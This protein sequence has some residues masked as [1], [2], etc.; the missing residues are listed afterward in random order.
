[1]KIMPTEL[2]AI[3]CLPLTR[4]GIY[5]AWQYGVLYGRN[6]AL[7]AINILPPVFDDRDDPSTV[8]KLEAG[9]HE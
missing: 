3:Q 2:M 4:A 1:M 7:D 9:D 6:Q 5:T 8:E